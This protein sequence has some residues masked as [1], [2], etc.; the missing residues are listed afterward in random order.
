MINFFINIFFPKNPDPADPAVRG[1]YGAFSGTVGICLNLVLCAIKF[2]AGAMSGSIAIVGDAINNLS[3]AATSVITLAGFRM[4]QRS[5][6]AEHPFGHGRMEYL[7]G[8]AVSIAILLMGFEIFRTSISRLFSPQQTTFSLLGAGILIVSVAVK[9]W[10]YFFYGNIGT[11]ITS[12]AMHAAAAD[13]LSDALS[14][15]AVLIAAGIEML[16]S[17]QIDAVAGLLVSCFILK[18]GWQTARDTI[19]PLLG[20][21]MP[22]SLATAIDQLALSHEQILGI[23]DLIYHDY[24]PGRSMMSFHAEVPAEGDFMQLH[25][26]IDHIEREMKK[27]HGIETVIHMDPIVRNAQ[28]DALRVQVAALAAEIDPSLTIHDFRITAGPMHTN[29]IFDVVVPHC[30]HMTDSA[31]K[32]AFY[33][34]VK[35]LSP[36]YYAVIVIDRSYIDCQ[37]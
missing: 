4:A 6:D 2:L 1:R 13:S 27:T 3:D 10:M 22:A 29:L 28:T 33:A 24:G 30:F 15:F 7:T 26:L 5:A 12:Q 9:I 34:K 35:Q 20:K 18:T 32:Q 16:F 11:R 23:H 14:T 37:K 8:L 19:D 25:D 31:V 36:N 17:L 21:P